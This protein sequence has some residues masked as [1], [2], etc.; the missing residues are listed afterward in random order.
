MSIYKPNTKKTPVL[1]VPETRIE[2]YEDIP[3]MHASVNFSENN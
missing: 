1:L 3:R 2:I